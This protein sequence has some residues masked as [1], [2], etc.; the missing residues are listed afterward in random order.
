MTRRPS[1][2]S[3]AWHRAGTALLALTCATPALAQERPIDAMTDDS[4]LA[5]QGLKRTDTP[6]APEQK[7]PSGHD[8]LIVPIPQSNPTL[9][10]GLTLAGVLF[11]NPNHAPQPW[12][13]GIAG[14]Y[15]S[16]KSW[17]VGA[18]HSMSLAQDKIRIVG[19]VGYADVNVNF[20]GIGPNAGDRGASV[21]IEDKGMMALA[22]AQYRVAP[23]F[24][25]GGPFQYLNLDTKLK[26]DAPRFPDLNPPVLKSTTSAIGPAISYDSRDNALNPGKGVLVNSVTMF[27]L[28]DLGSSFDY[29]KTMFDA[30]AYLPVRPGST[31]ALRG[32]FCGVSK[33]GPFYD[34]CMYGFRNDLR[35]YEAGRYRDRASWAAQAEWRQHLG[36]RFGAVFFGGVGGTAPDLTDLGD[37]KFL[38]SGGMGLRYRP[39]KKTGINLAVDFAIGKDSNA[40]Y[41]AIGE[42]F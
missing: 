4:R 22:Q 7:K 8:L 16:S 12:I 14:M 35:G 1:V 9:G 42:A 25:F 23:H 29:Q 20:Y 6:A 40:L 15:T 17:G 37:T 11:Y 5:A 41:I 24:Y 18:F 2:R 10:S 34:L 39:S 19:L 33:G 13:T 30:N 26:V 31:L 28:K 21:K 36:G 38:P 27:N 3:T 32:S